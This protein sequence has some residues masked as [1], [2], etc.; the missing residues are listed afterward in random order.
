MSRRS[1]KKVFEI[2]TAVTGTAFAAMLIVAEKK[3]PD[4]IY[5]N[6]PE[7]K[8]PMEGKQVAFVESNEDPENADG[9]RGHLEVTGTSEHKAGAYERYIKRGLDVILSFGGMVAFS[10]VMAAIA[11]AIKAEDSGPVLFTQKR[12]GRNK[13]YFKLHNLRVA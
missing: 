13:K 4:S 3:K 10:P 5:E 8:N 7:Q 12:I 11:I 6:A 1:P 2:I 9:L